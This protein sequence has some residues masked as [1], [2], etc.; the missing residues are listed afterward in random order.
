M[1]TP[2]KLFFDVEA[3][4]S[5]LA[6]VE[7][8]YEAVSSTMGPLGNTVLIES[9]DL[10][11]GMTV[12]KDGV[13]VARSISLID[14][15]ENMAVRMV[16]QASERTATQAGDGTTASVVLAR[17]LC[18]GI[19]EA[20]LSD[21]SINRTELFRELRKKTDQL[22]SAL[23]KMSLPIN[24]KR[25]EYVANISVNN[26][27]ELAKVISQVYRA[28]GSDGQVTVEKSKTT[29][30]RFETTHGF[31]I[32]R[33]YY[34][35]VFVNDHRKDECVLEKARVLVCDTD[36]HSVTQIEAIL[37][38]II[39]ESMSLLII[40]PCSPR[41]VETF[42]ANVAKGTIKMC[43]IQPPSFG[44]R[45]QELMSDIAVSTG[46]TYF[47]DRT[48]DDLSLINFSDLGY[49]DRVVVG[50]EKTVVI[51]SKE[52]ANQEE[53]DE[54]IEQLSLAASEA[55]DPKDKSFIASRI[56]ALSGGVGVIYVGGKTDIEQKELFDR[57][58][59]AVCAVKS[60]LE[61]GVVPGGGKALVN[62]F[63]K[64]H[65]ETTTSEAIE[66]VKILQAACM[67][68]VKKIMGNAGFDSSSIAKVAELEPEKGYDVK[69]GIVVDLMK[70]GIIDPT[71]VVRCALEN[72][73]SVATT[74]MST[75]AV[76]TAERE[77]V[78]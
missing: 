5:L 35:P 2:K 78:K 14:P 58:D 28:V 39:A 33:G 7:K 71:K 40:A 76:I 70:S 20:I 52:R 22:V 64:L 13:T 36:I 56:A 43:A 75:N 57:V 24:N 77:V 55:T 10:V 27:N 21:K 72:A 8:I 54:R 61:E 15:V 12:T 11:G 17:A 4:A 37:K 18:V 34:S 41:I 44:Y 74:I 53:I 31:T 68:P 45:Q 26:D 42:A 51:N 46:A 16:R 47:S 65:S 19:L 30:T 1:Y 3:R 59:D 48:G 69:Q 25:L 66:A 67:A 50:R 9:V 23:K 60:A 6:G 38:P 49:V 29:D 62:A 63:K 73:L 32:D